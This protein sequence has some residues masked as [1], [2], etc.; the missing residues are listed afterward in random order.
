MDSNRDNQRD[1]VLDPMQYAFIQDETK[2]QVNVYVG[3]TKASLGN[4]ESPVV[5]SQK[6]GCFT[7][8]PLDEA[9]QSFP[10]ADEVSYIVLN[11]PAE[12]D[13]PH[14]LSGHNNLPK[15]SSGRV[16]N[17]PGPTTFPLWP[18][19]VAEV[20]PGH[21]LRS[22]EYLV[23][24]VRNEEAAKLHWKNAVVKPQQKNNDSG[25]ED[26]AK[27]TVIAI[28]SLTT[29]QLIIIRGTDVSFYIPP[30]GIEVLKDE[31][32]RYLR[33]AA[34]LERLEYCIL[35]SEDGKKR[36]VQGPAVVFPEPTE[37]FVMIDGKV[38]FRAIE[39][40]ENM[41]L[42]VKVIT[43]YDQYH[44]GE[45][46]FITGKEQKIYFPKPEQ[47]IVSAPNG[48]QVHQVVYIPT[49]EARYVLNKS[50]GEVNL[51]KGP[52][53]LLPDPRKETIVRRVLPAKMVDLL[54]PNNVEAVEY[55]K[56]FMEIANKS[57]GFVLDSI[58]PQK[59][60][61]ALTKYAGA[62]A[63]NV[64]TGYAVNIVSKNGDR[65]VVVGPQTVLLEYDQTVETMELSTG[66]PKT[67]DRLLQTAYLRV[68]HNKVSDIIAVET[69]DLV[70]CQVK[71]SYRVDFE[72]D[73]N[74]W[75]DV[76]NY[77]KFLTDHLRSIIRNAVKHQGIEE[78]YSNSTT[79]VRDTVLG[80]Q[81]PDGKRPGRLFEEN[82]M[83]VYDVEVLEASITDT[84]I[85]GLLVEAQHFTV[86][87]ALLLARKKRELEVTEQQEGITQRIAEA[88]AATTEN[89]LLLAAKL[90]EARAEN[91]K[92][93]IVLDTQA[94]EQNKKL[95]LAKA[96]LSSEIQASNLDATLKQQKTLDDINTAELQRD[97]TKEDQK[98]E[99][100]KQELELK[101]AELRAKI[102]GEVDKVKVMTPELTAALQAFSDKE[103]TVKIAQA[104]APMTMFGGKNV[105][106]VV[107]NMFAGTL[108]E[109]FVKKLAYV[110][111]EDKE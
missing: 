31:T 30:S 79:L 109:G 100:A 104:M 72:G 38:K 8:V 34:T 60:I 19:Q 101:L 51:V 73:S 90:A 52:V 4:T 63:I 89:E 49:G 21:Q 102:Q 26:K 94:V 91:T 32:G 46:L 57:G 75:F 23:V 1:L 48:A 10:L 54:Y 55:N 77:V 99:F 42:H 95:E 92:K 2:G 13:K 47:T 37:S 12:G 83:R 53:T 45:E 97:K 106:E 44:A 36:Y 61:A 71:L 3:P 87:Q 76:E 28:P 67:T 14:P 62:V 96:M 66:K 43:D 74:L 6:D 86:Q 35:L 40:D 16:I 64:W 41:G 65:K 84:K 82:G 20:V 70:Q 7:K 103:T 29:G 68:K 50:S 98:M 107:H 58:V 105:A 5:F 11:N 69:R 27:E 108:M 18:G 85:S 9:I 33:K 39:L 80:I 78:F 59:G 81:G 17:L 24:R 93:Q 22:N 15:L 111:I 88:K 110:K 25:E 56:Q